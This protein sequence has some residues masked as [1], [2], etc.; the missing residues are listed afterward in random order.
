MFE[1]M[2]IAEPD[3]GGHAIPLRKIIQPGTKESCNFRSPGGAIQRSPPWKRWEH[4][5]IN[6]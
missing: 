6:E 3:F 4:G 1:R 5:R 2:R